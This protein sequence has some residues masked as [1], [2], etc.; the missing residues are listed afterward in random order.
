VTKSNH[1][2]GL[3][4]LTS[5]C[6]SFTDFPW[7]SPTD[8]WPQFSFSYYLLYSV[9]HRCIPIVLT[10]L[11]PQ[12]L[13]LIYSLHGQRNTENTCLHHFFHYCVASSRTRKLSVLHSNGCTRHVSWHVLHCCV[14]VSPS[15]CWCLQSHL[16]AMG[17]YVTILT[18]RCLDSSA[19]P[20]RSEKCYHQLWMFLVFLYY[21]VFER[22]V[23]IPS[24]SF[25]N[26]L[27]LPLGSLI[28]SGVSSHYRHWV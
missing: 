21:H 15:N 27:W 6:S 28:L 19:T 14:Q 18:Y 26:P 13:Y 25:R 8:N 1:T 16:P 9:V 22:P 23:C 3:H 11:F 12:T 5:D 7:L 20:D 4:K 2:L 17:L 10:L 24:H